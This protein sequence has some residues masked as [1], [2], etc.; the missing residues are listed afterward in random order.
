[1][2]KQEKQCGR[3]VNISD[4][5]IV[6]KTRGSNQLELILGSS[7]LRIQSS[8]LSFTFIVEA[9]T[10]RFRKFMKF[11]S[12]VFSDKFELAMILPHI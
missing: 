10:L 5:N 11:R 6:S 12:I 9:L 2:C 4:S 8:H 7:H 3:L 1:M